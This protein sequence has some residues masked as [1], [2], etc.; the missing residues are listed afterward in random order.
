[1]YEYNQPG[2]VYTPGI[3][4]NFAADAFNEKKSDH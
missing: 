4:L 2:I 1:M 3:K